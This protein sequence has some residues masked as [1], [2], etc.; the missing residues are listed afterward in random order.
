MFSPDSSFW[1]AAS[2][3]LA[4]LGASR[5]IT[6]LKLVACW[7]YCEKPHTGAAAWQWNNPLNTTEPGYGE[8]GS[9]NSAG[10]KIYATQAD[11]VAATVAT[12]TN[13]RYP[14]LVSAL[15]TSNAG[16]FFAA[17]SEMATWGTDLACIHADYGSIS[18][19]PSAY[20]G[21]TTASGQAPSGGSGT[22]PSEPV[23]L[24]TPP[25]T[26]TPWGWLLAG[27]ALLIGGLTVVAVETEGEWIGPWQRAVAWEREWA[28]GQLPGGTL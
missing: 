5:T 12:L 13:G 10:V 23:M 7:S 9:V 14:Q 24:T 6:N 26:A 3:I 22:A 11:G 27:G 18:P 21:G 2:A 16:Q 4:R 17:T 19:P 15:K 25:A 8:T 1:Q 20:L 28:S